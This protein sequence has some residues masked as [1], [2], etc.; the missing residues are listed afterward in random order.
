MADGID[1]SKPGA[2]GWI[3]T[4]PVKWGLTLL[5]GML[6]ACIPVLQADTINLKALGVAAVSGLT[7]SLIALLGMSSAGPRKGV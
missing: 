6:G 2:G 5:A 7:S 1:P 4:P 3:P